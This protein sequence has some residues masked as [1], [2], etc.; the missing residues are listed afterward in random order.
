MAEVDISMKWQPSSAAVSQ[1]G[2]A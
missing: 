1:C 2:M